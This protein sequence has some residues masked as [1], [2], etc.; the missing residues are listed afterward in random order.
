LDLKEMDRRVRGALLHHAVR[1]ALS[2]IRVTG[3]TE[4]EVVEAIKAGSFTFLFNDDGEFIAESC[5]P[6]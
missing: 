6:L 1:H 3:H 5:T 4:Q 2:K